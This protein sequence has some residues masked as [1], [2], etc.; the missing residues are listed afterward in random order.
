MSAV[1]SIKTKSKPRR[2][3]KTVCP[4]C[5]TEVMHWVHYAAAG[6]IPNLPPGLDETSVDF[7]VNRKIFIHDG[8]IAELECDVIV[9]PALKN[10]APN[11]LP[12]VYKAA[13]EE[14]SKSA[15]KFAPKQI[16]NVVETDGFRL[17]SSRVFHVVIPPVSESSE[18]HVELEQCYINAMNLLVEKGYESI[19]FPCLGSKLNQLAVK[20]S[21]VNIG[22]RSVRQWM[23]TVVDGTPNQKRVGCVIFCVFNVDDVAAY[24]RYLHTWF[25]T[26]PDQTNK[27]EESVDEKNKLSKSKGKKK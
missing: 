11:G 15:K 20:L 8:S 6:D 5:K 22:L 4:D 2:T 18:S 17:P 25:P 26:D 16:T 13:G 7:K 9:V 23:D 3:L 21:C 19:A 1:T 27:A 24:D 14:L 10:M 12:L